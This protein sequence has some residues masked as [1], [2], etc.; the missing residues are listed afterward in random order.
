MRSRN[1]EGIIT[2][3]KNIGEADK[4][5]T[6]FSKEEGKIKA[7]ARGSRKIKSRLASQIEL[8]DIGTFQLVEG[9]TFNIVAGAE[10]KA[11]GS[12]VAGNLNLF[13]DFAYLCEILIQIL[14]ESVPFPELYALTVDITARLQSANDSQRLILLDYFTVQVLKL[15][16][17]LPDILHCSKCSQP[18]TEQEQYEGGIYG[19]KCKNCSVK[20]NLTLG[21]YKL[22]KLVYLGNINQIISI[23]EIEKFHPF[24]ERQINPLLLEHLPNKLKSKQL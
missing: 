4:L 17:F 12:R 15:S 11:V 7:V 13:R 18:L 2:S 16:G 24:L 10:T 3:R 1:V 5:L 19:V 23:K 21:E 22:L 8:F 14:P 6:I 20:F 9:K